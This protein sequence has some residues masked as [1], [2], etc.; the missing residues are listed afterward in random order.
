MNDTNQKQ[1]WCQRL[2]KGS[3]WTLFTMFAW[4]MVEELIEEAIAHLITSVT[5]MF[6]IKVFSTFGII[7]ITQAIKSVGKKLV[8]KVVKKITYKEGNDK[9]QK[10]KNFFL[11]VWANKK[12]ICGTIASAVMVA[13][14]SGIIDV[15]GFAPINIGGFNITPVI[16]YLA[17]GVIAVLGVFGKGAES[18]K[19]FFERIG[20]LKAEKEAKAIEKEAKRELKAEE[21][22]A[23]QTQAEQ[24]KAKAKA[25]YEAK[26]KAEKEKADAE[27]KAKVDEA[28]KKIIAENN[29]KQDSSKN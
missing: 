25:E 28:K 17:L 7:A 16:Y 6:A 14:G 13:S 23:N 8:L 22:L 24:E 20:L 19:T 11:G 3:G 9:M 18:I 27:H 29:A 15:S 21:K 10:V 12:T 1:T 2:F 4:E 5:I 26:L